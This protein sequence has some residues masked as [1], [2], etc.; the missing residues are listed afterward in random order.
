MAFTTIDSPIGKL[1]IVGADGI[2]TGVYQADHRPEPD[3]ALFGERDDTAMQDAAEELREYFIGLRKDFSVPLR[4][5][6]TEFQQRVWAE[7]RQIPY[8]ETRSYGDIAEAVGNPR[9][10]RAVGLANRANPVTIIVPCHRVVSATG[11]L[12]GYAGGVQAKH[13]LLVHE[14]ALCAQLAS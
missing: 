13:A 7:I 10:V 3:R 9:A 12:N 6:G 4:L 2:V 8:G 11:K 1:T 14:G 5:Y